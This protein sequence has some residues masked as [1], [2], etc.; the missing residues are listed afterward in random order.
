[1]QKI[2]PSEEAIQWLD[3]LKQ[4]QT[5][6]TSSVGYLYLFLSRVLP[7]FRIAEFNPKEA[8]LQTAFDYISKQESFSVPELARICCIS[9]SGIYALF[10]DYAHT[11]PVEFKHR[12]IAKRAV[13]MLTTTD[14]SVESIASSLNLCSSAY[15]RKILK[16]Q[17]G[18]TPS[19]IRK[20]AKLI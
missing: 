5:V 19:Q 1:M 13:L 16:K 14:L 4:D 9:E 11:T 20:E 8:I 7:N 15:L 17:T 10:R 18:Q 6:S 2:Y 12:L 3:R